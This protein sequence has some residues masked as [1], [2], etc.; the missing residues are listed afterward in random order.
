MTLKLQHVLPRRK[1]LIDVQNYVI[2]FLTAQTRSGRHIYVDY[3]NIFHSNGKTYNVPFH[4]WDIAVV[5]FFVI[6]SAYFILI[7]IHFLLLSLFA[8]HVMV[9]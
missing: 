3:N 1:I 4:S 8:A 2:A 5:L 6:I 9:S 7:F